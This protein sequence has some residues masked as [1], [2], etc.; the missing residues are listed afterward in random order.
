MVYPYQSKNGKELPAIQPVDSRP[1]QITDIGCGFGPLCYML[2]LLSED[3]E[4]LGIDYDEDKIALAQHG[5]LRN[6][7]LQFKHGNALEYPCRK[8][9]SLS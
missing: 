1:R 2:S 9:M 7:H 3:R 5:W 6:E 8:V 4:I